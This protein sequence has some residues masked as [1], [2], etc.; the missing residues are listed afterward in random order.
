MYIPISEYNATGRKDCG[1]NPFNE[2][3][4][5]RDVYSA[6]LKLE[7]CVCDTDL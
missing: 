7:I 3:N 4:T 1:K 2:S 5:C 6:R